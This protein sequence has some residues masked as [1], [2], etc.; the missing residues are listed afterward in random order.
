MIEKRAL[1]GK[2]VLIVLVFLLLFGTVVYFKFREGNVEITTSNVVVNI[3][4]NLSKNETPEAD[5]EISIED[6]IDKGYENSL[7]M[8]KNLSYETLN[9]TN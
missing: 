9:K 4:Y 8:D 3:D 2:I 7:Y 5:E 6:R 1:I